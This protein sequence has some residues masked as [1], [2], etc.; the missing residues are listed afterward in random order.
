MSAKYGILSVGFVGCFGFVAGLSYYFMASRLYHTALDAGDQTHEPAFKIMFLA[1]R[2]LLIGGL[3]V[4][5]VSL[6]CYLLYR[7][8]E[9]NKP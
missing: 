6:I 9:K 2:I 4:M 1:A 5:I 7:K 3:A 8:W